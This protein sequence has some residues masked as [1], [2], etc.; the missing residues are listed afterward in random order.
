MD[1]DIELN[2]SQDG[3]MSI[4]EFFNDERYEMGVFYAVYYYPLWADAAPIPS[5]MFKFV[6]G[7]ICLNTVD[8]SYMRYWNL[9]SLRE[10][11]SPDARVCQVSITGEVK[12]MAV[13]C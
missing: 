11:Y 12:R 1:M 7:V 5:V 10:R 6:E 4:E 13:W 8:D 3:K 9:R 2:F